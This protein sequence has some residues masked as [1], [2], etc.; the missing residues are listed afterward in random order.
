MTPSQFIL[1]V[2]AYYEHKYNE[3]DLKIINKFVQQLDNLEAFF[4][5]LITVYSKKWKT[6]P[7]YATMQSVYAERLHLMYKIQGEWWWQKLQKKSS[8]HNVYIADKYVFYVVSGYGSWEQF[9]AARDGQYHELTHKDF[10]NRYVE[11]RVANIEAVPITLAGQ[12]QV[13]YGDTMRGIQTVTVGES[14]AD[15][16][17][18]EDHVCIDDTQAQALTSFVQKV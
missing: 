11:A 13:A 10:I 14:Q 2:E 3:V 12:L 5:A 7:D 6:L 18:V 16:I 8:L 9:C 1:A 15:A 17:G 4:Q